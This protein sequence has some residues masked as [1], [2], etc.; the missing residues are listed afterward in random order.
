MKI[1]VEIKQGDVFD[2]EYSFGD[3]ERQHG[4]MPLGSDNLH[5][6]S[7]M[8]RVLQRSRY[9]DSAEAVK[10]LEAKHWIS[11]HPE[12]AEKILRESKP[13]A[14]KERLKP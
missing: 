1:I 3:S 4:T 6:F 10:A 2:Y 7:E 8:I 12:E 14:E 11:D 5:L 9:K 13:A